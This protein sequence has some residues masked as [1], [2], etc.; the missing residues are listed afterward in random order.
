[1][2]AQLDGYPEKGENPSRKKGEYIHEAFQRLILEFLCKHYDESFMT[3]EKSDKFRQPKRSPGMERRSSSDEIKIK[4]SRVLD[5]S[6]PADTPPSDLRPNL[7]KRKIGDR[8]VKDGDDE[9]RQL[10]SAMSCILILMF[11][12]SDR[13]SNDLAISSRPVPTPPLAILT[14]IYVVNV[15]YF[16]IHFVL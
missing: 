11:T 13:N 1:M 4:K 14:G 16:M 5:A 6:R 7:P 8:S 9:Y 12:F 10:V 15:C 3:A 2:A